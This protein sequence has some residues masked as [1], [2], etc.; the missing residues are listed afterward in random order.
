MS[1]HLI[2]KICLQV[3]EFNYLFGVIS[4]IYNP[5]KTDVFYDLFDKSSSS[6]NEKQV[7]LRYSL[8][9]EEI[10]ELD[11][12]YKNNDPIEIIDALCDILYVVAGAKVYFNFPNESSVSIITY[13]GIDEL[14][15]AKPKLDEQHIKNIKENIKNNSELQ[16]ILSSLIFDIQTS[17]NSLEDLTK[18]IVQGLDKF[19]HGFN[20]KIIQYN[21]ILD[22]IFCL[23]FKIGE[24]LDLNIFELFELVHKSNMSKVC[25]D[26]E[27][28]INTVEWYKSNEKRY[29]SPCYKEIDFN[30]K[31]YWIVFDDETKKILKS[32]EYNPVKFI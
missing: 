15:L 19:S 27:I 1:L 7:N 30:G 14:T 31:T 24:K 16:S 4:Y 11:C 17:N 20:E 5:L 23:V 10:N 3:S 2:D 29:S 9:N 13:T 8:I 12:A 28:A 22:N 26:K 6:F 21:L 18:I 32:I 25:T